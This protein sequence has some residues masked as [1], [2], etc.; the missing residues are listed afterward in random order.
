[1]T[2]SANR[3]SDQNIFA[4]QVNLAFGQRSLGRNEL[5]QDL[6]I[7]YTCWLREG[8][9]CRG[10]V[11]GGAGLFMRGSPNRVI[12]MSSIFSIGLLGINPPEGG[13]GLCPGLDRNGAFTESFL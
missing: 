9:N 2:L 11:D 13:F 3:L 5:E 8:E 4:V 6:Y 12:F 1:M 10:G 7:I